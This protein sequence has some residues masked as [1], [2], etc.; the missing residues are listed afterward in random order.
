[1]CSLPS[2]LY[3]LV[4]MMLSWQMGCITTEGRLCVRCLS[5]AYLWCVLM[6]KR[7]YILVRN[8]KYRVTQRGIATLGVGTHNY[9]SRFLFGT[10]Q[11]KCGEIWILVCCV[12]MCCWTLQR[13]IAARIIEWWYVWVQNEQLD[14]VLALCLVWC[15]VH[16]TV[17]LPVPGP[18]QW[19]SG[20]LVRRRDSDS[21]GLCMHIP[22]P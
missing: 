4:H 1:M 16:F 15:T 19:L 17:S 8:G 22:W 11:F 20:R 10:Q 6:W 9:F 18:V 14:C 5:C 21:R 2:L 7:S 13:L 3:W 12:C